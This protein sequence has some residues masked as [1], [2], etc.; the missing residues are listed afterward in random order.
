MV[1]AR[2]APGGIMDPAAADFDDLCSLVP[3]PKLTDTSTESDRHIN[4]QASLGRV[5]VLDQ[6]L[7]AAVTVSSTQSARI[8]SNALEDQS[9]SQAFLLLSKGV[10]SLL[11]AILNTVLGVVDDH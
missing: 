10:S 9:W 4:Q 11:I 1:P 5:P 3:L 2:A 7:P 8:P 6:T